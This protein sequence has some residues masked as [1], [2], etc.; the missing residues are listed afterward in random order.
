MMENSHEV[1][2][3]AGAGNAQRMRN[4]LREL[5][6]RLFTLERQRAKLEAESARLAGVR[7]ASA[8]ATPTSAAEGAGGL[9][10]QAQDTSDQLAAM[11][12]RQRAHYS[13]VKGFYKGQYGLLGRAMSIGKQHKEKYV[14]PEKVLCKEVQVEAERA[15]ALVA[16][17]REMSPAVSPVA[18]SPPAS[19]SGGGGAGSV[20]DGTPTGFASAAPSAAGSNSRPPSA[21]GSASR[22]PTPP[23]PVPA[24]ARAST[25]PAEGAGAA[26]GAAGEGLPAAT[27]PVPIIRRCATL[28]NDS[29]AALRMRGLAG[30]SASSAG[31][32]LSEAGTLQRAG[33]LVVTTCCDKGVHLCTCGI[34][35]SKADGGGGGGGGGSL[36]SKSPPR[37]PSISSAAASR[38]ERRAQSLSALSLLQFEQGANAA[39]NRDNPA[40]AATYLGAGGRNLTC[41]PV[42]STFSSEPEAAVAAAAL[43]SGTGGGG[44]GGG[45]LDASL[46]HDGECGTLACSLSGCSGGSGSGSGSGAGGAAAADAAGGGAP[47]Q[48]RPPARLSVNNQT[49]AAAAASAAISA[50]PG[51]SQNRAKHVH[52]STVPT[53]GGGEAVVVGGVAV[54]PSP[55]MSATEANSA[56]LS[57]EDQELLDSDKEIAGVLPE[58]EEEEEEED[59]VFGHVMEN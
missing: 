14:A 37:V 23:P 15:A 42:T 51:S 52:A 48:Q 10:A 8:P 5:R 21:A 38:L 59:T 2:A 57:V 9:L 39:I 11:G 33:S 28:N 44:G 58:E 49:R 35:S 24:P 13:K 19:V 32:S 54:L 41:S 50:A 16:R 1:A 6:D 46:R 56:L 29:L 3:A 47:A 7:R 55:S 40:L 34:A 18:F 36:R 53:V 17:L 31:S 22:P 20:R 45:A 27:A 4:T 25:P 30:A 12:E 26:A 43:R